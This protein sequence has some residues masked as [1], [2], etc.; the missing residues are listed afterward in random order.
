MEKE[1]NEILNINYL[2][3]AFP[4]D[5]KYQIIKTKKMKFFY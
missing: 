1:F 4:K 2:D 3:Y 5:K